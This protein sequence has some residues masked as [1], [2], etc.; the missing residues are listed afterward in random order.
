MAGEA[1]TTTDS[2]M[3]RLARQPG[4]FDFFAVVRRLGCLHASQPPTGQA[5]HLVDEP[6]RFGQQASLAFAARSIASFLPP[7]EGRPARMRVYFQGLLGPN[8]PMPL[9][10]TEHVC[11]R[12]QL[13][14]DPTLGRF[15][16]VF[17]HRALSLFYRA[18]ASCQPAVSFDRPQTDRLSVYV[19]S[20]IGMG[21]SS[22]CERDE[23][24]DV[25]KLYYAGRLAS[26]TRSADGLEAVLADYFDVPV[27]VEPFVGEWVDVPPADRCRL[28]QSRATGLLGRNAVVGSR[29]WDCQRRFRLHVG[30]VRLA[31]YERLL[32]GGATFRRLAAWVRLYVG[33]ELNWDLQLSLQAREVPPVRLGQSGRLGWTS[34]LRSRPC[35]RDRDDLVLQPPAA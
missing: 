11:R 12:E 29:L 8:G 16:D 31:Q 17:H 21:M 23:V 26:P 33:G 25:A 30:P 1:G 3:G 35:E 20:L 19:A 18:W 28:G 15:L 34:W 6:V 14:H 5:R 13:E 22:H 4:A 24:P 2:L 9:Y 10:L 32:P 7:A 27:R